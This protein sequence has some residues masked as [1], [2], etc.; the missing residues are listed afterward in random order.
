MKKIQIIP[1]DLSSD[2]SVKISGSKSES[3]RVLVLNSIFKN[4][5]ISN[6]SDSDDS[7]VLKNSLKN[8]NKNIDIHHA[9]TAMRFLTAYLSTIDEGKFTLT[10][11]K[12]MKER[13]IGILVDALK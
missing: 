12:R 7:I 1:S 4:I 2:S 3:N 11:S 10:G 6:L 13:P 9:G 8:L 5:K